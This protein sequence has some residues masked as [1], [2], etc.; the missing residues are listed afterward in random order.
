M[1]DFLILIEYELL[2]DSPYVRSR[3]KNFVC[4]FEEITKLVDD[5]S[6]VDLIYL[7]LRKAFDKFR[8]N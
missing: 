7:D 2:N 8:K 4:F 5:G 6:P 3:L 1:V